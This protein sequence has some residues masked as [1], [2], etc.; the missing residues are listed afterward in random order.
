M[1]GYGSFRLLE[2]VP[3]LEAYSVMRCVLFLISIAAFGQS[4]AEMPPFHAEK[5]KAAEIASL[6]DARRAVAKAQEAL[7]VVERKVKASY[8]DPGPNTSGSV[9]AICRYWDL[10]VELRG[11]YALITKRETGMCGGAMS[12]NSL[13]TNDAIYPV[14]K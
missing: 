6:T 11:E 9:A 5:L 4:L 13:T 3:A 12:L 8:G 10:S 7:D 2:R 1:D 14:V